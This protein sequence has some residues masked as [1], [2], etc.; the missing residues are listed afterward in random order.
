M[1][2]PK[3]ERE[4]EKEGCKE[5]ERLRFLTCKMG[6]YRRMKA[7]KAGYSDFFFRLFFS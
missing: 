4:R 2:W 1:I 6:S 7:L 3:K 5:K